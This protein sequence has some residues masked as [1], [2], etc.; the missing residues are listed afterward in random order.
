LPN[1]FHLTDEL[2]VTEAFVEIEEAVLKT[3]EEALEG[4]ALIRA[5]KANEVKKDFKYEKQLVGKDGKIQST[6]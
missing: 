4:G 2:K 1:L 6:L 3:V 5:R